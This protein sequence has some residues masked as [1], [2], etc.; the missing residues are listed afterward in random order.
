M[1]L[2]HQV[3]TLLMKGTTYQHWNPDDISALRTAAD[4]L[5]AARQICSADTQLPPRPTPYRRNNN[6]QRW[7]EAGLDLLEYITARW[8]EA[9][10]GLQLSNI[11][12][13]NTE[14]IR[15]IDMEEAREIHELLTTAS[16]ESLENIHKRHYDHLILWAPRCMTLFSARWELFASGRTHTIEAT[17][18]PFSTL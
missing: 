1:E 13:I 5:D 2:R 12:P 10:I 3:A 14:A 7:H 16:A 18:S 8:P 4:K 9:D 6:W 11:F 15:I 17:K